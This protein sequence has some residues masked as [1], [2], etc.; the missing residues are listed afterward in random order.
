MILN[1]YNYLFFRIYD[2]QQDWWDSGS[3]PKFLAALSVSLFLYINILSLTR[4]IP[5][6]AGQSFQFEALHLVLIAVLL[7]IANVYY[8]LKGDRVA[9]IADRYSSETE[10][11]RRLNLGWCL[12]YV[13]VTKVIFITTVETLP[14]F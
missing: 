10:K 3:D 14:A 5:Y 1:A 11:D 8:F 4:I 7:A 12:Y 13:V 6:V 9:R 2:W